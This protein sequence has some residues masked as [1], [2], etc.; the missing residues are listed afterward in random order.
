MHHGSRAPLL[1]REVGGDQAI[2]AREETNSEAGGQP[3][4][5]AKLEGRSNESFCSR[6]APS[7]KSLSSLV[8][9]GTL[10]VAAKLW[11]EGDAVGA[12]PEFSPQSTGAFLRQ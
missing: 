12:T 10:A 1:A 9:W 8:C 2:I 11:G 6:G 4:L 7:Y 5:I 3:V